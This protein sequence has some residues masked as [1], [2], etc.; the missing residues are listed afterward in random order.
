M[1]ELELGHVIHEFLIFNICSISG[2]VKHFSLHFKLLKLKLKR[3]TEFGRL[4]ANIWHWY[5]IEIGI[6]SLSHIS[7]I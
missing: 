1:T 7:P 2:I 3:W 6:K 4:P 5:Q